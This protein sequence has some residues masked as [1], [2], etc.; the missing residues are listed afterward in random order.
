M[1]EDFL[2][3]IWQYKRFNVKN[4]HTTDNTEIK[5]IKTGER[6]TNA[7]PDFCNSIICLGDTKWAGNI[8]IHLNASDWILH[9][10]QHDKA[11][12]NVILHVVYND[13]KPIYR[14]NGEQIST[15]I[16]NGLYDEDI[17]Q[18]YVGFLNNKQWIPCLNLFKQ[19]D[20]F[21]IDCWLFRLFAERIE[22]KANQIIQTLNVN[23]NNMEEAF[24]FHIARA[25]GF[26]INSEPFERLARSLPLI[27]L[28]KHKHDLFQTEALLFGQAGFLNSNFTDDYPNHLKKEYDFL[29]KKYALTPIDG[30]NWKFL[31]LRPSNFP[32]IRIAQFACLINKS[33]GLFSKIIENKTIGSVFEHFELT[34]ST[35]WNDHFLFDKPVTGK[36]KTFGSSARELI[37]INAV[38]P[39]L[40]VYGMIK[41]DETYKERAIR[42]MEEIKPE[43]NTI[44]RKWK[45]VGIESKNAMQTQALIELKQSFCN[46][47]KCLQ[48]G[49]GDHLLKT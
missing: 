47:F 41:N 5:I 27:Q 49:I 37:L 24:Y 36:E 4:L 18:K 39:F 8:E 21:V 43:Q 46:N 6:N 3:Y 25:F 26:G 22:R 14:S 23:I 34:C 9:N 35:Y 7:G 13:D 38:V 15:L 29:K 2:H 16:I 20:K 48:C 32:T 31:R 1:T 11:Y 44:I 19:A 45:D 17:Y 40:F 12:D 33:S 42:F 28:S 10:H 30:S